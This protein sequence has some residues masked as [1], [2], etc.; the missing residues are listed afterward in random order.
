MARQINFTY[1]GASMHA[2][3]KKVNR[4]KIYGWS[5]TEVKDDQGAVCSLASIVDGNLILPSGSTALVAL[6]EKGEMVDKSTLVG[7]NQEGEKVE[8]VPS[9]YDQGVELREATMEEYFNLGVKAVYQLESELI[10][11][12]ISEVL[13]SGKIL[14]FIYNYRADYEGDDAFLIYAEDT[15][16]AITG[17]CAEFEFIG[18]EDNET[19]LVV[20]ESTEEEGDDLD[21]AMF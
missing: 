4:K 6:D 9:V 10:D 21:F 15:F 3:L 7:V 12:A 20:E 17:K 18:L 13:K 11:G 14:Y 5:S 2:A 19:E 1:Q 16:F 8:K